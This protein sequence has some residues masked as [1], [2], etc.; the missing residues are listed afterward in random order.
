MTRKAKSKN[1]AKSK[2][3]NASGKTKNKQK[4]KRAKKGLPKPVSDYLALINDPCGGP[5]TRSIGTDNGASIL[6][7]VRLTR[8]YPEALENVNGYVAWFPGFHNTSSTGDYR[9]GNLFAWNCVDPT[10]R[11]KNTLADPMGA[12]QFTS[13]KFLADPASNLISG[14]SP[15]SRAKASSAC[16]QLYSTASVSTVKG[17]IATILRMSLSAFD[18]NSGFAA[19]DFQPP[20]VNDLLSYAAKRE[21][22]NLEGH[23]LKWAPTERDSQLRDNANDGIGTALLRDEPNAAFWYGK[24]GTG[25]TKIAT[26]DPNNI[27]GIIMVFS[28][29]TN[30]IGHLNIAFTK[31]VELELAPRSAAIE[32]IPGPGAGTSK[33][34]LGFE[35]VN[36]GVNFMDSNMPGWRTTATHYAGRA[37]GAMANMVFTGGSSMGMLMNG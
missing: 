16:I 33:S 25:V 30:E 36:D 26:P 11:P 9:P 35:S 10:L 1:K 32:E 5:L 19:T 7:R 22:I 15:F 18:M 28:N 34:Y 37:A 21:R 14:S 20:S 13:G 17:Q 27:Y 24:P 12:A 2:R 23:E 6:E 4:T 31:T 8:N 3:S 29:V